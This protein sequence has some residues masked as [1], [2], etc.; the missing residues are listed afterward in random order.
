MWGLDIADGRL[1][2]AHIHR[3]GDGFVL[4]HAV[5]AS[6][7]P[8][9]GDA[10]GADL[11]RKAIADS[12]IEGDNVCVCL[13]A[14]AG[15]VVCEIADR[16]GSPKTVAEEFIVRRWTVQGREGTVIV[17]GVANR[18]V[19][20]RMAR[21]A[22]MAGLRVAHVVLPQ[23]A[24]AAALGMLAESADGTVR[25]GF[26]VDSEQVVFVMARDGALLASR[27][28][29][30]IG[31]GDTW[32]D[33]PAIAAQ[34]FRAA[35]MSGLELAGVQCSI[36]APAG[37]DAAV[38]E[39]AQRLQIALRRV[40][41]GEAVG[42]AGGEGGPEQLNEYAVAAG[43]VLVGSGPNPLRVDML[44]ALSE[45]EVRKPMGA[46][47]LWIT[48]LAVLI[49][50]VAG[51]V[52]TEWI[53]KRM[54]LAALRQEYEQVRP[55][56]ERQQKVSRTWERLRPWL[57]AGQDGRRAGQLPMLEAIIQA[58]PEPVEAYVTDMEMTADL[59]GADGPVAV[60]L[61]GRA[62]ASDVLHACVSRL[63]ERVGSSARLGPVSAV[64]QAQA[65]SKR[66]SIEITIDTTTDDGESK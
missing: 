36:I 16:T 6:L 45:G 1:R 2:L 31:I 14:Q 7:D 15:Y 52:V 58:F 3:Q 29:P 38:D 50:G 4:N 53:G 19:A 26:V 64:E 13:P 59:A 8:D 32:D 9:G 30:R 40:E 11:L 41:P 24:A 55:R 25:A 5:S 22:R 12:G 44:G 47:R 18:A 33:V 35:Q 66:Y 20:E 62:A 60:S 61:K 34:M 43:A 57:G 49:L 10:I 23:V 42:L 56:L 37:C 46:K 21:I 51:A 48:M 39:M 27:S 63:D 54:E 17:S 28:A 65:Y